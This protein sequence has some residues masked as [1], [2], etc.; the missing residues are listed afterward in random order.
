MTSPTGRLRLVATQLHERAPDPLR[1][2]D[3]EPFEGPALGEAADAV[4]VVGGEHDGGAGDDRA[5]AGLAGPQLTGRPVALGQVLD[6]AEEALGPPVRAVQ[7]GRTDEQVQAGPVGPPA[8]PLDLE[9]GLGAL[10]GGGPGQVGQDRVVAVLGQVTD[11]AVQQLGLGAA[12]ELAQGAVDSLK[13]AVQA[14]QRHP[15]GG[16]VEAEAEV[17]LAPL[18]SL[19]SDE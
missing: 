11:G 14:D 6:L 7:Q 2:G 1:G 4:G 10:A 17:H 18:P 15:D 12:E 9:G 16:L 8:A 3:A 5:Q 13:A 19:L